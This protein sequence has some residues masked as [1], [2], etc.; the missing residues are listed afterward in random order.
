MASREKTKQAAGP[1]AVLLAADSKKK[2]S[3][4]VW[5]ARDAGWVREAPLSAAHKAWVEAQGFKGGPRKHLLLPGPDGSLAGAV[6]GLGE[7]RAGD[8]MDRPELAVGHLAGV[9]PP[10]CY[11]LAD[12]PA[13]GEL[14][15]VAWGLGAYRF[16]R[17]KSGEGEEAA[18]LKLPRG[19]DYAR[20]LSVVEGIWLGR[21][22]INTPASDLGPEE[23]EEA[24]RELGK[25]HGAIV[26]R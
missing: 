22:L 23:L 24:A 4:P 9:L 3:L 8:P 10:G 1:G 12:E 16:R 13:D 2:K 17:Y 25:R 18:Q 20:A 5:L 19:A 7:A 6:L 21:D 14:A 11:H 15:A 26:F